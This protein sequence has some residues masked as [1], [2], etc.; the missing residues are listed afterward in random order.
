MNNFEMK[1]QAGMIT[2]RDC[3][4]IPGESTAHV[5]CLELVIQHPAPVS[6]WKHGTEDQYCSVVHF[7]VTR[8]GWESAWRIA[9]LLCGA[10]Y[11]RPAQVSF[12]DAVRV[13]SIGI[14]PAIGGRRALDISHNTEPPVRCE[15]PFPGIIRGFLTYPKTAAA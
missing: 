2:R 14:A 3:E 9:R 6:A 4:I 5:E 15:K 7:P 12:G 8:G 1:W 10:H 13:A 11:N